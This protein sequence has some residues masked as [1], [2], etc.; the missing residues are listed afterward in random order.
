MDIFRL[1]IGSLEERIS[2]PPKRHDPASFHLAAELVN[3][4][5]RAQLLDGTADEAYEKLRNAVGM[6]DFMIRWIDESKERRIQN[7]EL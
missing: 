1:S 3:T 2:D 6:S 5:V 4:L 7:G